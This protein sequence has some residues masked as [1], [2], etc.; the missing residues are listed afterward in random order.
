MDD[1]QEFQEE[2]PTTST[3]DEEALLEDVPI[4]ARAWGFLHERRGEHT[5]EHH[6][7]DFERTRGEETLT[8]WMDINEVSRLNSEIESGEEQVMSIPGSPPD[9]PDT[10]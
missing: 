4:G 5:S 10:Q 8:T 7:A 1:P 9:E 2:M 6:Q 3:M